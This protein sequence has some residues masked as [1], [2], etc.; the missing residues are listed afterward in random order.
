M[1]TTAAHLAVAGPWRD[2]S[3]PV[4]ERVADLLSRMTLAEKLAQLGS[5]WIGASGDGD[6]VA[7]M[8]HEFSGELPPVDDLLR[9]GMGQPRAHLA[10]AHDADRDRPSR[11][12][13]RLESP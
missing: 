10:T 9:D 13:T 3:R 4:A 8:Q 7:P 12:R 2:P 11:R 6:G 1:K 5:V